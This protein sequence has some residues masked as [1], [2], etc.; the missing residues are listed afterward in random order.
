M[1]KTL[2]ELL[3]D[4]MYQHFTIDNYRHVLEGYGYALLQCSA[5]QSAFN[6]RGYFVEKIDGEIVVY[7]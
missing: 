6:S 2:F 4:N 3:R 7:L 1:R 5:L